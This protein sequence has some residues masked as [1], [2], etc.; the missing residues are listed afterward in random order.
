MGQRLLVN[1]STMSLFSCGK[2]LKIFQLVSGGD[3]NVKKVYD[4]TIIHR[5]R[6][7]RRG[8]DFGL[9]YDALAGILP[10][11]PNRLIITD[12]VFS[13]N[14]KA[15]TN[16][17]FLH[18]L[19]HLFDNQ[20]NDFPSIE[21]GKKFYEPGSG[22]PISL[23]P[24]SDFSD[25][26]RWREEAFADAFALRMFRRYEYSEIHEDI[27][28]HREIIRNKERYTGFVNWVIHYYRAGFIPVNPK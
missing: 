8:L 20:L 3:A 24:G 15:T 6:G 13:G 4:G 18:E 16:W 14:S 10:D 27:A 7:N 25:Y 22:D 17:I 19:G 9:P 5:V 26:I 1:G 28:P 11:K 23:S 21:F 2:H 12:L